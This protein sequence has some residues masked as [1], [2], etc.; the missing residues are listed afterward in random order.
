[1]RIPRPCPLSFRANWVSL[2]CSDLV[3]W[4]SLLNSRPTSKPN[5][6]KLPPEMRGATSLT[7]WDPASW[8]F[9]T[10][11]ASM[12]SETI[13]GV[14]TTNPNSDA[15]SASSQSSTVLPLP[16]WPSSTVERSL[17]P[18]A[19]WSPSHRPLSTP[20]L[21]TRHDGLFPKAGEKIVSLSIAL[22]SFFSYFFLFFLFGQ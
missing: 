4:T 5:A 3:S 10:I 20:S 17:R 2:N 6:P 14:A 16:R 21:P 8:I 19:V 7:K 1:M 22:L 15:L 11:L 13:V 9:S 18:G 12:P